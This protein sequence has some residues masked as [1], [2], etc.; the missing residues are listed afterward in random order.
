V[1]ITHEITGEYAGQSV[2]KDPTCDRCVGKSTMR[3]Q[4]CLPMVKSRNADLVKRGGTGAMSPIIMA[5][6][7]SDR[8][9]LCKKNG[10]RAG[11]RER[12]HGMAHG[13]AGVAAGRVCDFGAVKSECG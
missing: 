9:L 4:A 5:C 1:A 8:A 7:T 2:V 10:M 13:L 6:R 11:R 3:R 12:R